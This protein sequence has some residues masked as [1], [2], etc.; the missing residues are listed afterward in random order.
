M[1][2]RNIAI[3]VAEEENKAKSSGAENKSLNEK[4]ENKQLS[5]E[6]NVIPSPLTEASRKQKTQKAKLCFIL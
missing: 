1:K 2:P 5:D 4:K 6:R 3:E